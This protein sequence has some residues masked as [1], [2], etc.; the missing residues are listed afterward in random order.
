M[1][2]QLIKLLSEKLEERFNGNASELA[3]AVETSQQNVSNFLNGNVLKPHYWKNAVH[4]LGI[5]EGEYLRLVRALRE[6]G[7]YVRDGARIS[8]AP[9][10][11]KSTEEAQDLMRERQPNAII[12]PP[13]VMKSTGKLLPVLGEAVGG[14]DG[15][16]IFNGSILDY[17]ACPPSLENVLG[18]YAVYIDGESMSPRYKPGETVWVHPSKPP[19]R[20]DDVIVQIHPRTDDG[21]PPWGYVKEFVGWQGSRLVL[22]QHNPNQNLDFERGE[23]VSVHP[24]VL[25]GKY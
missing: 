12:Q 6:T 18:A 2:N 3:R 22:H 19:R 8:S 11:H 1:D 16:Y 15:R 13:T 7:N 9:L 4:A 5:E 17:V 14:D 21:S 20:G 24:I 25:S 23:V 10:L